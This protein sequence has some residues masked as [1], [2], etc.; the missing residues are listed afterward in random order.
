MARALIEAG[1]AMPAD[2]SVAV[3]AYLTGDEATLAA[4]HCSAYYSVLVSGVQKDIDAAVQAFFEHAI[5]IELPTI[6]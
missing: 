4:I 2:H 5:A 3:W 6:H 1:A